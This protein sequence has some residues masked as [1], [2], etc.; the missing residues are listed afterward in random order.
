MIRVTVQ[1]IPKGDETR[2]RTLGT[3]EIANDGTGDIETGH[4]KGTLHAEYTGATGRTGQVVDFHR[5]LQSVWSLIGAFLKLWGHTKH[6]PKKMA[7]TEAAL[8]FASDDERRKQVHARL[9]SGTTPLREH[10]FENMTQ[11]DRLLRVALMAY[12]RDSYLEGAG[13]IGSSEFADALHDEICNTVGDE[14]YCSWMERMAGPEV[15]D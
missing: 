8:P 10:N 7:T 1:L 11:E 5:Q 9:L 13:D 14:A 15:E 6:S 2:A 3:M 4:Y 12:L